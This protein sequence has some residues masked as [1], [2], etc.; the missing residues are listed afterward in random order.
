MR[1]MK[2]LSTDAHVH[3]PTDDQDFYDL[4]N[5]EAET[6]LEQNEEST[7]GTAPDFYPDS[8]EEKQESVPLLQFSD[9]ALKEFKAGREQLLAR[10]FDGKAATDGA[11]Q[12]LVSAHLDH[13]ASGQFETNSTQL[14]AKSKIQ[15]VAS[16]P[17][18]LAQYTRRVTGRL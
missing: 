6:T 4:L 14:S 5:K 9:A 15:K 3:N 17:E 18:T 1:G 8:V 7:E 10:L 16:A 12:A 13:A 2:P 11:E